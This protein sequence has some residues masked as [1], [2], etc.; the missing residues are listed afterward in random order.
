MNMR[1]GIIDLLLT[2][3]KYLSP[4]FSH[5]L[6]R[7]HVT[8]RHFIVLSLEIKCSLKYYVKGICGFSY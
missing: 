1:C 5:S 4:I 2:D 7:K 8:K 3:T 6:K